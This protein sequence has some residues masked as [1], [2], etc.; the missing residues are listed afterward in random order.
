MKIAWIGL[1]RNVVDIFLSGAWQALPTLAP[2]RSPLAAVL[3]TLA[4]L[5]PLVSRAAGRSPHA[6]RR[7]TALVAADLATAALGTA[8][9]CA[10]GGA[11]DGDVHRAASS[12]AVQAL[13]GSAA[14]PSL[15]AS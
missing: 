2:P 7:S 4:H 9:P 8:R 5:L 3:A 6:G 13:S 12:A 1:G 10:A 14:S 11:E 15:R